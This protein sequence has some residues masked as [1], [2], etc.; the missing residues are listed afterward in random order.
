VRRTTT[1]I[2]AMAA[3]AALAVP[4]GA[5]TEFVPEL[6]ETPTYL[7]CEGT[8]KV[9]QANYAVD[10]IEVTTWGTDAPTQS[11]QAGAGC[12][13]ADTSLTGTTTNN[14]IYDFP[15]SGTFTGNLDAITVELHSID[16]TGR[17]G[18]INVDLQLSI[19]GKVVLTDAL[20]TAPVTTSST[21]ATESITFTITDLDLLEEADL[22]THRVELTV[23]T[24]FL[25]DANGWVWGTTE[26]PSGLT[27]NPETPEAV[28]VR[29]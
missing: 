1:L 4:A 19:D 24:H 8:T 10:G 15:M 14:P 22:K 9:A 3:A 26:V 11:V 28:R 18:D 16:T 7:L 20:V 27:F 6:I 25:D 21:G 29:A 2:T 12:G 23:Q 17:L 5:Q 13:S